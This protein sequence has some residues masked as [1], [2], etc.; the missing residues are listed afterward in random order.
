VGLVI[1]TV[2]MGLVLVLVVGLVEVDMTIESWIV[3]VK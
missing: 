1:G 3:Y 2:E